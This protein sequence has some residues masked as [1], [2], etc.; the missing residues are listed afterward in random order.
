MINVF[1]N[2]KH[3][4]QEIY[5]PWLQR[6]VIIIK[7]INITIQKISNVIKIT[8]SKVLEILILYFIKI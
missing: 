5:I 8:Q 6:L 7:Y 2:C 4:N 3:N 1:K